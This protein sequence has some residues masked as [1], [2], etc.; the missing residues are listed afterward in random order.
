M[1][2]IIVAI[3]ENNANSEEVA[4]KYHYLLLNGKGI[5]LYNTNHIYE[6]IEYF[7]EAA[8]HLTEN[9]SINMNA[10]QA[11]LFYIKATGSNPELLERARNYLDISQRLDKNNEKYQ[12]LEDIYSD[13]S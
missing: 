8:K 1:I 11:I 2:T 10:A 13:V 3:A 7:E 5:R 12:K 6:S 9:I 4:N